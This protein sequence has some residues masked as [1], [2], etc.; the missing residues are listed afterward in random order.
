MVT[1]S[2]VSHGHSNLV[3]KLLNDIAL[4]PEVERIIL[5]L[6][7]ADD[8]IEVPAAIFEKVLF[9]ENTS[10]KGFGANHNFAFSKCQTDFFCVLNP[11][12][13]LKYNPFKLLLAKMESI[14]AALCAPLVVNSDN[15]FEDSVR[16]FPT[17]FSI[18]K[19]IVGIRESHKL[20]LAAFD[21]SGLYWVGGMFMLFR[22][23]D[24][25]EVNG[26]DE[27]FYLYYEDVDICARLWKANKKIY[28]DKKTVILHDARR[29][30][31]RKVKFLRWHIASMCRFFYKHLGRL[32]NFK[33]G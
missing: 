7:I 24:F 17:P 9:I 32:P 28:I 30:S 26:F 2:I 4:C 31:H 29:D 3:S 13:R 10:Q 25:H 14:D 21:N 33:E 16:R 27:G 5:T 1:V 6:N 12:V 22:S 11:D 19:K 20:F 23:S 18:A 15:E 8:K